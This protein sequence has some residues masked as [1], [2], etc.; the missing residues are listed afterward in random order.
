MVKISP[1]PEQ[2]RINIIVISDITFGDKSIE[3]SDKLP[4]TTSD[5]LSTTDIDMNEENKPHPKVCIFFID[6]FFA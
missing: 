2:K 5:G 3:K 6:F 4:T 1:T